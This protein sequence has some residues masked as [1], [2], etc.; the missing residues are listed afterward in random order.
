[1]DGSCVEASCLESV[2]ASCLGVEASCLK[3]LEERRTK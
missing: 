3:I 1:M 2:E